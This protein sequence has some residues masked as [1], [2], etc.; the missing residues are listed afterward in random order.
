MKDILIIIGVFLLFA[1]IIL[2]PAV[3][4]LIRMRRRKNSIPSSNPSEA[5]PQSKEEK[6]SVMKV[7]TPKE[8]LAKEEADIDQKIISGCGVAGAAV[9]LILNFTTGVVPGGFI[10]GGIGG[11]LG[12][13]VGMVIISFRRK[14]EPIESQKGEPEP[15]KKTAAPQKTSNTKKGQSVRKVTGITICPN[16]EMKVIPKPDGTCPNCQSKIMKH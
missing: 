3:A 4:I 9:F 12:A 6:A 15:T 5:L 11:G 8:Q 7:A 16:C 10:G 13:V 2:G 14:V 1:I